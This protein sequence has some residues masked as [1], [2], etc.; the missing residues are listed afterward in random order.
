M[1][2]VVPDQ[3]ELLMLHYILGLANAGNP[4]L[5]LYRLDSTV[6]DNSVFTTFS[7]GE[8]TSA[9]YG[10]I[11][12]ASTSWTT[13]QLASVSTGI[14]SQVTFNFTTDA[15]VYGYWLNSTTA[16][17]SLLWLERFT[18]A[19]FTIPDGGGTISITSKITLS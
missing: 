8:V 6:D 10:A 16:T 7:S 13:T 11:T 1:A 19:P 3:G 14:F 9:G 15:K 12:L 5:H 17:T 2:L 18:G 4:V